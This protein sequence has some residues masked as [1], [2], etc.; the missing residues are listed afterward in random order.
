MKLFVLIIVSV[1]LSAAGQLLLRAGAKSV[2]PLSAA[3]W[4]DVLAWATLLANHQVLAGL[5]A[6]GFSTLLW[7]IVLSQ[8]EL[9]YAYCLG[10]INYVLVPLAASWL[11]NEHLNVTRCIGMMFI[12]VGVLITLYAGQSR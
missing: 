8:A 10:S 5:I 4:W 6:W 9:S 7:L 11:F 3:S 2:A 12:C 1:A